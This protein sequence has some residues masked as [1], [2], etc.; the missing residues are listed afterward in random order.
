MT[1]HE[2]EAKADRQDAVQEGQEVKQAKRAKSS[3]SDMQSSSPYKK[4]S[5]QSS[6]AATASKEEAK[7]TGVEVPA[8]EKQIA[9]ERLDWYIDE[10]WAEML[11]MGF[12]GGYGSESYPTIWGE[13]NTSPVAKRLSFLCTFTSRYF[14]YRT[15]V[16]RS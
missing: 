14:G 3:Q 7:T 10:S 11:E 4:A 9:E 12:G 16:V 13:Q 5:A 8:S 15:D 6:L 2:E 1:R